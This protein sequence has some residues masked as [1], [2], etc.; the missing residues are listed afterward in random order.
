MKIL[1]YISNYKWKWSVSKFILQT[2]L[3]VNYGY[4]PVDTS[5]TLR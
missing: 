2:L 5:N 3:F 4:F 1:F